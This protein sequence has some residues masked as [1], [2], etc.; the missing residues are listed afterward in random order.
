[1]SRNLLEMKYSDV[2]KNHGRRD[3]DKTFAYSYSGIRSIERTPSHVSQF[4]ACE[5]SYRSNSQSRWPSGRSSTGSNPNLWPSSPGNR[6]SGNGSLHSRS[7][8]TSSQGSVESIIEEMEEKRRSFEKPGRKSS[9]PER[10]NTSYEYS[11]GKR[12]SAADATRG[13]Q[14][15]TACK[16]SKYSSLHCN[17]LTAY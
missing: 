17:C 3:K 8:S 16:R 4:I 12:L 14:W 15:L 10:L 2:S 5:Y 7:S 13:K 11:G 6:L 1:M 9:A